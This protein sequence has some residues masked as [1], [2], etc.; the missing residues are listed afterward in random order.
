MTS[1]AM[2]AVTGAQADIRSTGPPVGW[3]A[4][5]SMPGGTT[6][7]I[8]RVRDGARTYVAIRGGVMASDGRLRVGPDP[9]LPAA[10]EVAVPRPRLDVVDVWPGPRR[11]WFTE[12]AWSSLVSSTFTVAP[13][14]NRVGVRLGGPSLDR[15]ER[16][17]LPSEG[18]IEGAIQVPPN[19]QPIIML[20]D[21]PT[22]GGYPVIAVVEPAHLTHVAQLASGHTIR[23][24]PI[25]G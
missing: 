8:G 6:V 12:E 1:A 25:R 7:H 21:H 14:S 15:L 18:L 20:A 10:A 9:G 17:E 5:V 13:D 22:T 16:R 3:G 24:R 19:G 2:I 4:P 11:N 23:F